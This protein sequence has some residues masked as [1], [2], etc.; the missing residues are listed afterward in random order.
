M[1]KKT[2]FIALI[3]I[4]AILFF[5]LRSCEPRKKE[6]TETT[7]TPTET[8]IEDFEQEIDYR[9]AF[10]SANTD[11]TCGIKRGD[12]DIKNQEAAKTALNLAYEKYG[13]PT[14]NDTLL[15]EILDTYREDAEVKAIIKK[16]VA[17]CK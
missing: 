6:T 16:N 15:I 8:P 12:I 7:A 10:I 11:F 14:N 13:L 3:I 4:I 1:N 17:E 5:G 9:S 2:L